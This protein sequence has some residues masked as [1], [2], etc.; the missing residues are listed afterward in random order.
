MYVAW[1]NSPDETFL[2]KD[3]QAVLYNKDTHA[4]I[5]SRHSSQR[6]EEFCKVYKQLFDDGKVAPPS[7][8]WQKDNQFSYSMFLVSQHNRDVH[9][10]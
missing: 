2:S 3:I 7:S 1:K 10:D 9:L 5:S 4:E 8:L 6:L